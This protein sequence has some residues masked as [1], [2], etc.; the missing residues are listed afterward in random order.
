MGPLVMQ[1]RELEKSSRAMRDREEALAARELDL[2]A[3]MEAVEAQARA[4]RQQKSANREEEEELKAMRK[5]QDKRA[6]LSRGLLQPSILLI[7]LPR[8][9][10]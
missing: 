4:A 1:L 10:P 3:A 6:P 9:A 8:T 7:L 5:R 2:G